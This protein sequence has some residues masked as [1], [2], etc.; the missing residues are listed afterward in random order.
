MSYIF[1]KLF[2][3]RK[4]EVEEIIHKLEEEINSNNRKDVVDELETRLSEHANEL[5]TNDSFFKLSLKCI[6]SIFAKIEFEKNSLEILKNMITKTIEAHSE[7][8]ETI[9]LLR[10]VNINLQTCSIEDIFSIIGSFTNCEILTELFHNQCLPEKDY[11]WQLTENENEIKELKDRIRELELKYEYEADIF[12]ACKEGKL[13]SVQWLI[14]KEHIDKNKRVEKTDN[15][16]NTRV[17]D[18][19]IHIASKNDHLQIVQYLIEK[20]DVDINIKGNDEKMP[21]HYACQCGHFKIA[22]YLISKEANVNEK[23][24]TGN[25]AI[26]YASLYG[27][28]P[29]I[30]LLI[31]GKGVNVNIIGKDN[32]TP[33]HYICLNSKN[34]T[35]LNDFIPI[36]EYLI[37]KGADINAEDSYKNTAFH[38]ASKSGLLSVVK[39]F[40]E[41]LEMH[42]NININ[43]EGRFNKTPLHYACEKGHLPIVD[44]LI[45]NGAGI[46]LQDQN[47]LTPLHYASK[48]DK[49]DIVKYLVSHGAKKNIKDNSG[50]TPLNLTKKVGI[51]NI[52]N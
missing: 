38:Y 41:K 15:K 52:L 17:Y 18:T 40:V 34:P 49:V 19:P 47:G 36:V 14:E 26:H 13:T 32:L 21:I 7:E 20:Q 4:M 27:D 30:K 46:N 43:I 22:Q 2:K 5:S 28:L 6:I 50:S 10:N 16:L 37:L 23:D 8:K 3:K 39:Y 25:Y 31:E 42:K 51:K 45:S 29:I 33:L 35:C 9:L 48:N 24:K 44:Y 11:S 1:I 12:K